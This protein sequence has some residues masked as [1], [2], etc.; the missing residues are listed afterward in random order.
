MQFPTIQRLWASNHGLFREKNEETYEH[1]GMTWVIHKDEVP[2]EME[3]FYRLYNPV[4][5]AEN[6]Y[7]LCYDDI[8]VEI[9]FDWEPTVEQ[10]KIVGEKLNKN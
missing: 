3:Y 4:Y 8:I 9:N 5:G 10:M 7:L 2:L 1:R 6:W